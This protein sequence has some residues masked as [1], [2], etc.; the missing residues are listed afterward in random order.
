MLLGPMGTQHRGGCLKDVPAAGRVPEGRGLGELS[1]EE[2]GQVDDAPLALLTQL[3][4]D[5]QEPAPNVPC[6]SG[7]TALQ[8]TPFPACSTC[9][10]GPGVAA[11][12]DL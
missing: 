2:K 10:S 4:G 6:P 9:P 8:S 5:L 12:S 7:G 1:P 3:F 11:I